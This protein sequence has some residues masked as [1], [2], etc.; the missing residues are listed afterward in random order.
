MD[1]LKLVVKFGTQNQV[2]DKTAV[3]DPAARLTL[4]IFSKDVRA[5]TNVQVHAFLGKKVFDYIHS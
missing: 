5:T 3:K 2:F 1:I 4:I